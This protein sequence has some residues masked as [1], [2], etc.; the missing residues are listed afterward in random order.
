MVVKC[1][2]GLP[3]ELVADPTLGQMGS[4]QP[5]GGEDAPAH[6]RDMGLDGL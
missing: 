1:W 6:C 4:Q 2:N 3:T 5:D